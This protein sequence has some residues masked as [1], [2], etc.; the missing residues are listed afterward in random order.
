[1]EFYAVCTDVETGKAVYKKLDKCSY[2]C[3]E[4]IRASASM[5]LASKIVNIGNQKLL[6]GGISDSIPLKYFQSIGYERN[7]VVTTQPEGYQKGKN[8]LLPLIR[9]SMRKFPHFIEACNNRHLMYN[10]Q[11]KHLENEEKKEKTLVLRPDSKL[12]IGHIS[13]DPD[14]MKETYEIGR[15]TAERRLSEM[16]DFIAAGQK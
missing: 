9:H 8:R 3:Y 5:P 4:W 7:L 16:L 13:H 11:L 1:M 12:E 6:D 14:E 10:E 15:K 2:E